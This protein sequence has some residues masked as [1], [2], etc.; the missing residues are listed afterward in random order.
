MNIWIDLNTAY[1]TIHIQYKGAHNSELHAPVYVLLT[2]LVCTYVCMVGYESSGGR[3]EMPGIRFGMAS[4]DGSWFAA[5]RRGT[6]PGASRVVIYTRCIP[7]TRLGLLQG[8]RVTYVATW[9]E[10]TIFEDISSSP[11][12]SIKSDVRTMSFSPRAATEYW[13][14]AWTNFAGRAS[15]KEQLAVGKKWKERSSF[16]RTQI[17]LVSYFTTFFLSCEWIF[18]FGDNRVKQ[19]GCNLC[20][21]I[22]I[23]L[24]YSFPL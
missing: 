4:N 14:R 11:V 23:L 5:F 6:L 13:N 20:N 21:N 9:R 1:S 2:F 16:V 19:L 7:R 8:F 15:R 10:K 12:V 18:V 22:Y 3:R 24:L 17:I